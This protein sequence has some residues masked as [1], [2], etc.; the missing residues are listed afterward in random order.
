MIPFANA[1]D[2]LKAIPNARLVALPGVGH[3]P[4]EEAPERSAAALRAFLE[5]PASANGASGTD[6]SGRD[7]S[8]R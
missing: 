3:L 5:S 6:S 8:G 1:A 7:A 4:Q 2:Y